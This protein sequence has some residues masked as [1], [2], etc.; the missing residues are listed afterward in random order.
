[1][2]L[3]GTARINYAKETVKNFGMF[4]ARDCGF[5]ESQAVKEMELINTQLEKLGIIYKPEE[6]SR[7]D[8]LTYSR[9]GN[10]IALSRV[11]RAKLFDVYKNAINHAGMVAAA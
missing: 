6:L 9:I 8:F 2:T 4:L 11:E 10:T 3:T 7:K 1:M 5:T